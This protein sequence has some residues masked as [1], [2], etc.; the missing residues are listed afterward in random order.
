MRRGFLLAAV[1]LAPPRAVDFGAVQLGGA[2]HLRLSVPGRVASISGA[3][4][5]ATRVPGGIYVVFEPYELREQVTGTL[6]LRTPHGLVRV[7]LRGHGIDTRK[8]FV[9]VA[10]PQ[11]LSRDVTIRFVASDNDLVR[12]CLLVANGRTIA[13]LAWPATAYRWHVPAGVH[14][15]RVTVVAIDRAGNRGR[16]MTRAF[17]IG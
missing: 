4:F 2:G 3:G 14:R 11:P 1:L 8:P 17:E 5:S 7:A 12:T 6:R 13:R 16:A 10:T 9:S 15:A